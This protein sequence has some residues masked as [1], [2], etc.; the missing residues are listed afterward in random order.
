M[1]MYTEL[2]LNVE[3]KQEV[4][5]TIINILK[6]MLGEEIENLIKP[7]HDLFKTK[8]WT[9]MLYTDSSYFEEGASS[10]L[11]Y[12]DITKSWILAIQCNFKNYDDEIKKFI[13]FISP[14][15]VTQGVWGH[16]RYEESPN[17]TLIIDGKFK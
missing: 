7:E 9:N 14:Y 6:Y 15:V 3:L 10:I 5:D 11:K 8:R 12:D 17:P 1:G 2:K 16:K 13:D 4:P